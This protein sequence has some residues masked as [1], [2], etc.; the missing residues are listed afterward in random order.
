MS[1]PQQKRLLAAL[2]QA[3][4]PAR[5]D[6]DKLG[7][8]GTEP[9]GPLNS[10]NAITIAGYALGLWWIAGGPAWAAVAS[11]LADEA[12]GMVARER[13]ETSRFGSELDWGS[14]I[15]L[16]ALT[17]RKLQAPMWSLPAATLG[18]C[19]LRSQDWRHPLGSMRAG[20]ML[21]GVVKEGY[22]RKVIGK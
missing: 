16:T 17:L 21:Y 6:T 11:V 12:D 2:K 4:M 20:L 15:I 13:G 9:S 14:D 1:S 19:W 18:Q 22:R 10:A 7:Q 3:N 5:T 8:E